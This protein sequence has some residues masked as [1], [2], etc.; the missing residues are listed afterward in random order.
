MISIMTD[1]TKSKW[2]QLYDLVD[3]SVMDYKDLY[4]IYKLMAEIELD[5]QDYRRQRGRSPNF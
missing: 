3:N 5:H 2:M 1:M 4:A